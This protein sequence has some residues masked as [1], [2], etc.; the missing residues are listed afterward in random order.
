MVLAAHTNTDL[1]PT[2]R[3]ANHHQPSAAEV[4]TLNAAKYHLTFEEAGWA[5]TAALSIFMETATMSAE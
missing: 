3:V 2:L 5:V 4:P 1:T